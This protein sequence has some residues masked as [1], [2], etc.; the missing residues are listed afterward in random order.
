MMIATAGFGA[1]L[2]PRFA[3][4][5]LA[6][7]AIR[8]NDATQ[9]QIELLV[10]RLG[11]PKY[12]IRKKAN[13]QLL[14]Y[15]QLAL[16]IVKDHLDHPNAEIRIRCQKIQ[17]SIEARLREQQIV[18]FLTKAAE[19]E[20]QVLPG[21]SQ[22]RTIAGDSERSRKW[23]ARMLRNNW[24]LVE[25]LVRAESADAV[26]AQMEKLS[27]WRRRV[28]IRPTPEELAT[29]MLVAT[30]MDTQGRQQL[31]AMLLQFAP[32]PKE[33][34]SWSDPVF[35]KLA[36][37]TILQCDTEK[38]ANQAIYLALRR[39][40]AEGLAP[41]MA[42]LDNTTSPPSTVQFAI[43]AVARFGDEQHVSA[44]ESQLGNTAICFNRPFARRKID[45]IRQTKTDETA[46]EQF[47][48]QVRDVAVA[49]ALH[50]LSQDPR[51][52]GFANAQ[53]NTFSVFQANSLGFTTD[54]QRQATFAKWR[55]FRENNVIPVTVANAAAETFIPAPTIQQSLLLRN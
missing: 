49:A 6:T 23:L 22:L 25:T 52:F 40:M 34:D 45:N 35:R 47:V 26:Q 8:S 31:S 10:Q 1:A 19:M 48:V 39:D 50:L 32:K 9:G 37:H 33:S 13:D 24:K 3:I 44:L 21:W 20:E 16:P 14:Q 7:P 53:R 12:A 51:H 11:G 38:D 2:S 29:L 36:G 18:G 17:R 46:K 43:L 42:I 41:A 54:E 28:A 15:G 30:E 55:D 4:A 27:K 5:Q